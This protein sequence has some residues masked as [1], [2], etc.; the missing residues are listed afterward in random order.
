VRQVHGPWRA[1]GGE[2][3]VAGTVAAL[4]DLAM[5]RPGALLVGNLAVLAA[6]VVLAA[7]A[8]G[9][10]GIGAPTVKGEGGERA[11]LVVAT[12]G[13]MPVRSGP[14]RVALG[15]ISSQLRS[16]PE[17]ASVRSGPVSDDRRSTSLVVTM[18]SGD[19]AGRQRAVERIEQA[20][21]PG[22]LRVSF[23]GQV[24][25]LLEARDQLG[26]DL[27]KAGLLA[28]VVA[29]GFGALALGPPLAI[30]PLL[31]AATAIAGSLAGLRL[32][33]GLAD[34]SLLGIAPAAVLGL[35][36]GV[37]APCLLVAR[38]RDE[39][40]SVP[41]DQATRAALAAAGGAAVPIALA[42]LGAAAG[43]LFTT[44]DQAPSM[45]L[46]CGLAAALALGSALTCVPALLALSR[47]R[48]TASGGRRVGEPWLARGPGASARYLARSPASAGL[49]AILV[50]AL[51]IVA[52]LPLVQG[53]SRPFSAADLPSRS[54]AAKASAVAADVAPA[55]SGEVKASAGETTLFGRL[56]LAA[57]VSAAAIALVVAVAVSPRVV[58]VALVSL[59]PAA[60]ACGLCVLLFQEGHLAGAIGQRGQGALETGAVAS[61]LTALV[62]IS[63]ARA[64]TATRAARSERA[65]GLGPALVAETAA[66]F[67]VPAA[68]VASA[69]TA[70]A[71]AWLAGSGVYPA[72]EFGLAVAAGV[73]IDLVLLRVPLLAALAH[74][75]G[76][77]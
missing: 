44:F 35:A 25:T 15:V 72:R 31:C 49:A 53:E 28:A 33:G 14:Y 42:A 67:T 37:E 63:A 19:E 57:A 7:G 66:A 1:S 23:G 60:A 24:A 46:A 40:A 5:R 17:V 3:K 12:R 76:S 6:A 20:I 59:L 36:L 41:G 9:R 22:P 26:N 70:V 38:F 50:S 2:S 27:W 13:S 75:G 48:T 64:I 73:L 47:Y 11:D 55:V 58:P 54:E 21:D 16:D 45:V 8:P 56:P 34:I 71:T 68:I 18:A 51:M 65:L 10:L 69:V 4:A 62:A 30:A 77:D 52:A 74:W 39:A 43:I 61:I 32:V 29:L